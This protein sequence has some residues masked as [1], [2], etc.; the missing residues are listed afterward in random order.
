MEFTL[1]TFNKGYIEGI[2]WH[3]EMT[4]HCI[5]LETC[6]L[7]DGSGLANYYLLQEN[8]AIEEEGNEREDK[9][10]WKGSIIIGN[11]MKSCADLKVIL[12]INPG[13]S[14]SYTLKEDG[15]ILEE[16]N[17]VAGNDKEFCLNSRKCNELDGNGN[18]M[19][20][21]IQDGNFMSYERDTNYRLVGS[22]KKVCDSMPLLSSTRRSVD[23]F[24]VISS[25]S[26]SEDLI[27]IQNKRYEAICWLIY[28]D[29]KQLKAADPF[30]IQR[31]VLA[32]FYLSTNGNNW[33]SNTGFMTASNECNWGGVACV[34]G[35]VTELN[36]SK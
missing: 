12:S 18:A 10:A 28:D 11:C 1:H 14:Y 29:T 30:L 24:S 22:C 6:N 8:N 9:N 15:Y 3:G 34:D 17:L 2:L 13:Q 19:Y 20:I 4:M 7:L 32:L 25:V 36:Y 33:F 35:Y 16:G 5:N 23:I 21:A 26:A 27:D 31:Y